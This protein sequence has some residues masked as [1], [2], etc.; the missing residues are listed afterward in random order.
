MNL[1]ERRDV[2]VVDVL[3]LVAGSTGTTSDGRSRAHPSCH[4]GASA[5]CAALPL[6]D[7]SCAASHGAPVGRTKPPRGERGGPIV[8]DAQRPAATRAAGPGAARLRTGCRRRR[9]ARCGAARAGRPRCPPGR[10]RAERNRCRRRPGPLVVAAAEE[11]DGLGDDLD[12][13]R[14]WCRPGPPFAP[15]QAA[16]DGD[17]AALGEEAGAVLA[18]GAP[19]GDAEVV[20]LVDPLAVWSCGG[21]WRRSAA[22]RPVPAAGRSSG[23]RVRLPVRTTRL[24]LVADMV[25]LLSKTSLDSRTPSL[26]RGSDRPATVPHVAA[27]PSRSRD[28]VRLGLVGARPRGRLRRRRR[29]SRAAGACRRG[30]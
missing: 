16:V 25:C 15:V 19:D 2:L 13:S 7:L 14:A 10:R 6:E 18:L 5:G 27:K 4:A 22:C 9:R 23:S 1:P 29:P 28:E 21:C 17:R 3:D 30:A 11:L 20:G 8:A 12:R 26:D 24:M